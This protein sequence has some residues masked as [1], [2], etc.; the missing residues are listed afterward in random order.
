MLQKLA[1]SVE[2]AAQLLGLHP[3]TVRNLIAR[4]E[5]K[6]TRVGRRILIPRIA[7]ERLLEGKD[8]PTERD[9]V[10]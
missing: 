8:N 7:L 6:A 10:R 2:E 3:N 9:G 5:L 4:G 1:F